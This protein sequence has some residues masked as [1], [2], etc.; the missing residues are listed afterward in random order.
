MKI[1]FVWRKYDQTMGGVERTS[2]NLMNEMVA[3]G[4]DVSLLSWDTLDAVPYYPLSGKVDWFKLDA[5]DISKKANFK[6]RI[7]RILK[8]RSGLK[9]IKPDVVLAYMDGPFLSI[10]V[11]AFGMR[12][13]IIEAERCAVSRFDYMSRPWQK[14]FVFFTMIFAKFITVQV[15]SYIKHYP[16]FLRHKIRDIPNPVYTPQTHAKVVRSA[17]VPPQKNIL[18]FAGRFSYQKNAACLIEAFSLMPEFF[19][20]W[21]LHMAGDGEDRSKLVD[22]IE[23]KNIKDN[24]IFLGDL[25]NIG[26]VYQSAQLFCLPSKWEGFPNALAEALSY[27]LPSIGFNEC[28]GVSDLIQ[29]GYNGLLARNFDPHD[30]AQK[31]RILMTDENL[32]LT[33]SN[34][35]IKSVEGFTP[36]KI[37]DRWENVFAKAVTE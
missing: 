27:G 34:N 9:D 22:L 10:L 8:I 20:M 1:L 37:Y 5:G 30:L 15:H 25:K 23:Q 14:Y 11:S 33:M 2:I 13:P 36:D 3:R 26:P 35:A 19:G 16:W 21:E 7:Q 12:I 24:V 6:V 18:L 32:R 17:L 29:D 31:L 28:Y 4:H